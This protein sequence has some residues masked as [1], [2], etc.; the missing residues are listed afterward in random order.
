MV[1]WLPHH[2]TGSTQLMFV[3]RKSASGAHWTLHSAAR[4]SQSVIEQSR[5]PSHRTQENATHTHTHAHRK[6]NTGGWHKTK[7]Y[8]NRKS[9]GRERWWQ[10]RKA[11]TTTHTTHARRSTRP[12]TDT[13]TRA[14][15]IKPI[16]TRMHVHTH[17]HT[18]TQ[19]HPHTNTHAHTHTHTQTSLPFALSRTHIHT[20]AR[21]HTPRPEAHNGR[22]RTK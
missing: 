8:G 1:R 13:H 6:Q 2:H 10:R 5:S 7:T 20:H 4:G 12:P 9:Q 18:H 21:T 3:T 16:H 14:R 22:T 19:T 11:A 15:T 17:R